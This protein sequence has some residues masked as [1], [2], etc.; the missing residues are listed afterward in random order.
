MVVDRRHLEDALA[1]AL[2]KNTWMRRSCLD[3]NS[4]DDARTI[5][6]WSPRYRAE[7]TAEGKAAV[8]AHEDAAGGR[9]EPE[10]ASPRPTIA[11]HR[12][13]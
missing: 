8:I 9:V 12:D 11:A 2:V 4:A 6:C 3:T 13:E 5:S 10:E 7:R 1:G